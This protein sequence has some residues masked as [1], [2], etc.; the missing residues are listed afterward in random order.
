MGLLT[1]AT[2]GMAATLNLSDSPLFAA[3]SA[4]PL[5]LMTMGRDHKLYYEAYNDASDLNSDGILDVGYKPTVIDYYGYFGSNL[6]YVY[7][8]TNSR[9]EPSATTVTKKC[10]GANEWSGDF[11]NYLTTS[12]IDA[13]RKV[14]YGGSRSTDTVSTTVLERSYIPQDAHSWGKEYAS[15]ATD[16]YDIQ[17]YSPLNLPVSGTRHLFANTTLV[18]SNDPPLFRVLNDSYFRIWEWVSKE[19]PVA[20]STC[21]DTNCAQTASS[22]QIVPASSDPTVAGLENLTQTTYDTHHYGSYPSNT[23]DYD[24]LEASYA[25]AGNKFG[26]GNVS[27]INGSGNPYGSNDN[28]LTIF[29]GILVIPPGE[30]GIYSFAVDGDDAVDVIIDG[31]VVA[32]WYG[33]HGKCNCQ[34]HSGTRFLSVG[35]HTIK[36]RHQETGDGDNYFLY[37]QKARPA[38]TISDYVVRTQVCVAG[39]LEANCQVYPNGNYKPVGLLQSYGENDSMYFGLLTGS[40]EKNMS[41]GVLRKNV[42]SI[43]DEINANDGTYTSTIGVIGTMDRLRI[44]NFRYGSKDYAPGWP[45]AWVTNGPMTEGVI[46]DWGNPVAE[47]MYEGMR[48]FAGKATPT[49][50]FNIASSGNDDATLGLP[51]PSWIDPYGTSGFPACAKPFQIVIA[52]INPSYDS[53]QL[54]GSYFGG[55]AS[56]M[57]GV[58]VSTLANTITSGET[59]IVGNHFIGQSNAVYDGAPT[60]K[61]VTSLG[62]IRGL[63]PEEPTKEGSYYSASIGY[64][65]TI[66]DVN[67]AM[68]DQKIDTFSVA[69]ASPLPNIDIPMAG[70]GNITLVPFAKSVGGC[71]G[72][73][74]SVSDFQPTNTIVD[75]Y[76]ET[77]TPTYGKFRI[78]YEDVEQGAD[79]DMDAIAV[80]EYVVNGDGTVTINMTSTY[81][82]GCI[83]QHMGYIISG[84]TADG[85]YLEIRDVD[86]GASSDPDYFLDTP[87]IAGD[88]LPLV[89]S[90]TFTPGNSGTSATF[91]KDPLWYAAKWGGFQEDSASANNLPDMTS[92]WDS[93]GDGDPDNYF[94]VTNALNLKKQLSNAFNEIIA[95][96]GV[97]ASAAA[98]TSGEISSD[99][100]LIQSTFDTGTWTGDLKAYSIISDP[101]LGV[102][103]SISSTPSWSAV[104]NI[105]TFG[106]RVI[107]TH[108]GSAVSGAGVPF[109]WNSGISVTQ[110]AML[111]NNSN[112]VVDGLGS[113]RVDFLRGKTGISG[114]RDRVD[115]NGNSHVLGDMVNSSPVFV[116][117][118]N[119]FFPDTWGAG[120]P[121][122][123]VAYSTF[124]NTYHSSPRTPMV[125]VGANDGMLHGFDASTGSS[126]GTEMMA[127]V[128]NEVYSRLSA[129]TSPS[130]SHKYY[131]DGTPTISD[132]FFGGSWHSVLAAGLNRGGQ[133]IYALDVT[134]ASFTESNAASTVLWE[135][136][137]KDDTDTDA[138]M[139]YALGYTYSKPAIVRLNSGTWGAVFGNGYNNTESDGAASTTGDAVLYIL[140]ISNGSV[141]R[142]INTQAGMAEDP[143]GA[144][145]ANGLSDVAPVDTNGDH[146][147]DVVYAGDL[148]GNMWKFD[149]SSSSSSSWSVAYSQGTTPKPLFVAK[150]ASGNAQPIT[151]QP[152]VGYAPNGSD[153]M[154]YFGSGKYLEATDNTA[155]GSQSQNFYGIIDSGSRITGTPA[156]EL[157]EQTISTVINTTCVDIASNSANCEIRVTSDNTMASGDK[158]WFMQLPEPGER[159]IYRPL[160]MGDVIVFV[161]LIP[162]GNLC[163][164][165]GTG[166]LMELDAADGGRLQESPFDINGDGLFDDNDRVTYDDVELP[167]SGRLI[168]GGAPSGTPAILNDGKSDSDLKYQNTSSGTTEVIRENTFGQGTGRQAWRQIK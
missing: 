79:H 101:A 57:S 131:V 37:W 41:G 39:L 106:L 14:F 144:G 10:V 78:N 74:P 44:A 87:N 17:E 155:T 6:C 69:L 26:S 118:P 109:R 136:A 100:A 16:G 42:G 85:T 105:P 103:G 89:A 38:S 141:I 119:S 65:G 125:Y 153:L 15:I 134:S 95:R 59:G 138:D 58:N 72:I 145:R 82:S 91:L 157:L 147:V 20:G 148:F 94:L 27:T 112:G 40:Y 55:L 81:A 96:S 129:L 76:V 12:R 75:F 24:A 159:V 168:Q 161:T 90:R 140:D 117:N 19:R 28:Y 56:D 150:D 36:F 9:F 43:T 5:T 22:W 48:Y 64:Y 34:T 132:A 30:A 137:D 126:K 33:A 8:S 1:T 45:G 86:T 66:N 71:L 104:D 25:T 32:D 52:D 46:T 7:N 70:G 130:Y 53:N 110:Q 88:P 18:S 165:E 158:G 120:A 73:T 151:S 122:N 143:T 29:E 139:Q 50:E 160:L 102:V 21:G 167:G 54:P 135:Y 114:F 98:L 13:L 164:P 111:N 108:D 116:G 124:H 149:L 84:T 2:T 162:S 31:F 93:D 62:T 133:A 166:W 83:V 77:L 4:P 152:E 113:D 3:Q 23:A 156:I 47:M 142:K 146:I 123:A 63:A 35:N 154:V 92:E 107:L 97:S 11:L 60:S 99:T 80:Y 115:L 61:T 121:E 51:L 127:Y 163:N 128:P 68:G 49:P 67:P